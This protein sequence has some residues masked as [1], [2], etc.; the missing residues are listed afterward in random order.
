MAEQRRAQDPKPSPPAALRPHILAQGVAGEGSA[1]LVREASGPTEERLL[2]LRAVLVVRPG[3]PQA[4]LDAAAR[5][6]LDE[7][8]LDASA[9]PVERA[10][11]AL[12]AVRESLGDSVQCAML[13]ARQDE[14]WSARFRAGA[15]AGRIA[16]SG[17]RTTLKLPD[18]APGV[19]AAALTRQEIQAARYPAHDGDRYAI[20]ID[21][22]TAR[23]LLK[24]TDAIDPEADGA[25]APKTVEA[26]G[27]V[28]E[29][30]VPLTVPRG[31]PP[32]NRETLLSLPVDPIAA[33]AA[34]AQARW[35]SSNAERAARIA[36]TV[37]P[38]PE[39]DTSR[40]APGTTPYE[41][42]DTAARAVLDA[43]HAAARGT[44][45][46]RGSTRAAPPARGE[47][48]EQATRVAREAAREAAKARAERGPGAIQAIER[49]WVERGVDSPSPLRRAVSRAI[50]AIERRAPWL[51]PAPTAATLR[52]VPERS[53]QTVQQAERSGRR[54]AATLVLAAIL[55]AGVGGLGALVLSTTS[56]ELDAAAKARAALEQATRSVDEALDP[57]ANLLV[58]DPDRVKMLL[59][60][61]ME[62]LLVAEAGGVDQATVDALRLRASAT[63]ND[64]FNVVEVQP[65]GL[66]DFAAAGATVDIASIAVG[67]DGLPYAADSVTGAVY[68][69]DPARGR[70]TVVYQPGFDLAGSRTGQPLIVTSAGPEVLI[71]DASSNLWRWRPADTGGRG[72]L[73]K[74]RVRDGE[75][76]G[77]DVR[78]IVGFAADPGTGLYRLY[79][80][81]PSSRQILR[82]QPAPDGTGYPASPTGFLITPRALG[83]VDGIVIDGDLYMSEGGAIARYRGG[84]KDSW[85]PADPGDEV[86]RPAPRYTLLAS[87]GSAQNG[88]LYAWDTASRRVIAFTKGPSGTMLA[89]YL[90][91]DVGGPVGEIVGGYVLPAADGGAP[92]FVW[93]EAT[94]IRSAVLGTAVD[95]GPGTSAQPTPDP[96]IEAP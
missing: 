68:R 47:R 66:F 54:R 12:V 43:R 77:A 70:A 2:G 96:V 91:G 1:L 53:S 28:V 75:L 64:L 10:R 83:D 30:R 41:P 82:Y 92:T 26:A 39:G 55:I 29:V 56:P 3:I 9:S 21:Q 40:P 50:A 63:L 90:I 22:A 18:D 16:D 59:V 33:A 76:W 49:S 71:F 17:R 74:M 46:P 93:A 5:A 32:L 19:A 79:V 62:G 94:R 60:G 48:L 84:A 78:A 27:L 65:I 86:L 45:P 51:N 67:P 44:V 34:Q 8:D 95:P 42:I 81:D 7:F 36:A 87:T 37:P 58:N 38:K 11:R 80:V 52:A 61:A 57:Q 88:V 14:A 89:Q 85:A 72:T 6:A 23:R 15:I 73:V 25:A 24:R 35:E 31:A 13:G 4:A 20:A 69:I